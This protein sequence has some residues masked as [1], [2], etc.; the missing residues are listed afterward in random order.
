MDSTHT[1]QPIPQHTARQLHPLNYELST[2]VQ[3]NMLAEVYSMVGQPWEVSTLQISTGRLKH[4]WYQGLQRLDTVA[5]ML[6]RCLSTCFI[7]F[8]AGDIK[9]L[10]TQISWSWPWVPLDS[11]LLL[12]DTWQPAWMSAWFSTLLGRL[13]ESLLVQYT[14]NTS[15]ITVLWAQGQTR[16][17]A[18]RDNVTNQRLCE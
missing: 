13:Q 10:E 12:A 14:F 6:D 7:L 9:D 5:Y 15:N 1:T 11:T 3:P 8:M 18:H 16:C 4:T 17:V 2:A